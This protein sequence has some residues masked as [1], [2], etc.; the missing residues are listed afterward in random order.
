[1]DGAAPLLHDWLTRIQEFLDR[2]RMSKS[3]FG[4]ESVGD[5]S[6]IPQLEAG[7]DCRFSTIARIDAYMRRKDDEAASAASASEKGAA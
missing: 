1:M 3:R 4:L 6:L 5:R 2:H 7:R